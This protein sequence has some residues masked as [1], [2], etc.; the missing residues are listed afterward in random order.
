MGHEEVAKDRSKQRGEEQTFPP[1]LV[2]AMV[3]MNSGFLS[4]N[5]LDLCLHPCQE[6]DAGG[7]V[8]VLE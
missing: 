8:T 2:G 5:L 6:E 7:G 3:N 4:G 1:F